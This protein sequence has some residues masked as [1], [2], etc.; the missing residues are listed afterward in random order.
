MKFKIKKNAAHLYFQNTFRC[1]FRPEL[2]DYFATKQ[3][4]EIEGDRL[5]F[6]YRSESGTPIPFYCVEG[7]PDKPSMEDGAPFD[8]KDPDL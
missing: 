6:C 4:M 2:S 8:P 5:L 3:G 1:Q 7:H